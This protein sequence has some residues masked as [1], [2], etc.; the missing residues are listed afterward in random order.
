MTLFFCQSSRTFCYIKI[1]ALVIMTYLPNVL[2]ARKA[3]LGSYYMYSYFWWFMSS[4]SRKKSFTTCTIKLGHYVQCPSCIFCLLSHRG[5]F[6]SCW[7]SQRIFRFLPEP[8]HKSW[9]KLCEA[10]ALASKAF[11]IVFNTI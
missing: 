5:L 4:S 8:L 10:I 11:K 9:S 7:I 6:L 1:C 3:Q 2:K